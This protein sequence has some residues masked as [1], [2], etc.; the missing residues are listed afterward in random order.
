MNAQ[1]LLQEITDYCRVVGLA[2]TTFGRRAVNDGKFISRLRNG[3]RITVETLERV[4]SYI[5]THQEVRGARPAVIERPTSSPTTLPT[6]AMADAALATADAH[7]A[8][9]PAAAA[10]PT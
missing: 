4:R 1:E 5:A 3:G 7:S 10:I 9:A 6:P 8:S 2:E